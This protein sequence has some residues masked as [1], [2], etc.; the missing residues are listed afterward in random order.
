MKKRYIILTTLFFAISMVGCKKGFLSQEVNPNQPSVA[1]PQALLSGAEAQT[2]ARLNNATYAWISVW[3][4]YTC[5]SGNYV[6]SALLETYSF[7]NTSFNSFGSTYSNLTNYNA[8]ITL[9]AADPSAANFGAIGQIMSALCYQELVD[10]YNDVPYSQALN[11]SKYLFPA[12]DTGQ[13]IYN[14]LMTRLDGAIATI[15]ASGAAVNPGSS[16]II[17]GGIMGNWKKFAN[18]LKLRIALR[19][20]NIAANTAALKTEVAKTAVEGY[21]DDGTFATANPGYQ[22]QDING[23]QQSPFYLSYGYN[24]ASSE[25]GNHAY[26]RANN[27]Y[28]NYLKSLNDT[29]RLKQIFAAVHTPAEIAAAAVTG[30][31]ALKDIAPEA[32]IDANHVLGATLG[33]DATN[34]TNTTVSSYGPGLDIGPTMN[35]VIISGSEACFLLSE[36]VLSGYVTTGTAAQTYYERGI[37]ASFVALSAAGGPSGS[38]TANAVAYY[39]QPVANVNWA[40]SSANYQQAIITQKYIALIGFNYLEPYNEYRRT[41]YPTI[42][43]TARSVK[44]GA[45]GYTNI[46]N[47]IYYPVTEYQQNLAAVSAEPTVDPFSSTI[48]W[49]QKIK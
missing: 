1:S 32:V 29:A 10:N 16:D 28:V 48:F 11:S 40:A 21:L 8:L 30:A 23:G 27:V 49:A 39:S 24:A 45:L 6:P 46:I 43:K 19:Q 41:G 20:S 31:P 35:A 14:A 18:T 15:N 34:G 4:G 47:R 33:A 25:Q 7:T 12:Y 26:Y 37:T 9:A 38:A 2:A 36:G 44:S 3:M 13:S 42:A 17:F 5:P 22:N